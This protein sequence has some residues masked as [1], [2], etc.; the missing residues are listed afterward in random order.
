MGI[1]FI[2]CTNANNIISTIAI[3]I[4]SSTIGRK[5]DFS[6]WLA[7]QA[8]TLTTQHKQEQRTCPSRLYP[9]QAEEISCV[10]SMKSP[11]DNS[12]LVY[13]RTPNGPW[14][15]CFQMEKLVLQLRIILVK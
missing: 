14:Y 15:R 2:G 1:Y 10:N 4:I 3:A 9:C 5:S 13:L 7:I 8:L 6:H 12:H 11:I